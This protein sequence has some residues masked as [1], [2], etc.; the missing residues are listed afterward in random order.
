MT[1][2]SISVATEQDVPRLNRL[3]NS[4]YRGESSKKGWTSEADLLDGIRT[5]EEGLRIMLRNPD[6]TILTYEE[7]GQLLG[8]VALETKGQ[9]LYL[10]MLTVSPEA[11]TSGI[12][13]KIVA[14]AEQ[15]AREQDY[16]AIT[17]TVIAVRH[18]LIAW[19]ERRGYQATGEKR[20][21]PDD[22]RFGLP[23]QPLEFIVMEK[24]M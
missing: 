3:V 4:A 21:F 1:T 5:D 22:P 20:P 24:L 18:E 6:V 14:S 11:Q 15:I 23:K 17:M 19:Y 16:R 10:G 7:N 2:D 12:G 13:K 9:D 8:C